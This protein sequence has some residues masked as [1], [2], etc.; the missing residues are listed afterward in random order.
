M[1]GVTL[2]LLVLLR[3]PCISIGTPYSQSATDDDASVD[4]EARYNCY[5]EWTK[6][7]G[8]AAV[9]S[10]QC[11]VCVSSDRA[12]GRMARHDEEKSTCRVRPRGGIGFV[13][14]WLHGGGVQWPVAGC[15]CCVGGQSVY[16]VGRSA[17]YC[18]ATA[19]NALLLLLLANHSPPSTVE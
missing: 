8:G 4:G 14:A 7:D 16:D 12:Q 2:K 9:A 5:W 10:A 11:L 19:L 6:V 3:R 15:C 1:T 17:L 13:M 18:E